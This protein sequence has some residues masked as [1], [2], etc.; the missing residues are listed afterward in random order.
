MGVNRK[1][2]KKVKGIRLTP[3]DIERIK[4]LARRHKTTESDII[5]RA[6]KE[7]DRVPF[8]D[9][10]TKAYRKE[11]KQLLQQLQQAHN[12]IHLLQQQIATLQQQ[13]K[14]LQHEVQSWRTAGWREILRWKV[15]KVLPNQRPE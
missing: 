10:E 1:L 3:D 12:R 14:A 7:M 5:S 2:T 15:F 9:Y 8:L 11:K 4:M 13:L 6:L